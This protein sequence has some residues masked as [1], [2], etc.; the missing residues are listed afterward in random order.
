MSI[1]RL[2]GRAGGIVGEPEAQSSGAWNP[3][4]CQSSGRAV[5]GGLEKEESFFQQEN[6]ASQRG[7]LDRV[8]SETRS[9]PG[10]APDQ[11]VPQGHA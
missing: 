5:M 7:P 3:G 6:A 10:L 1:W 11:Q 8:S 4:T 2:Y 9:G